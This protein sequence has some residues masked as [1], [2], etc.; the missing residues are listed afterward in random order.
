MAIYL[1]DRNKGKLALELCKEDPEAKVCLI[2]DGVYLNIEELEG[3]RAVMAIEAEIKRRGL[4]SLL[5][6]WVERI[7]YPRLL[8]LILQEKVY[9]FL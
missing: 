7:D 1:V 4:D 5:P 9:N 3:K 6:S 8:E 2:Q